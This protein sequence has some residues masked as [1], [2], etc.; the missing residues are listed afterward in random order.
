MKCKPKQR[1]TK[2][3]KS[4]CVLLDD[5]VLLRGPAAIELAEMCSALTGF[6]KEQR[7]KRN[8]LQPK[9]V[10]FRRIGQKIYFDI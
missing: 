6:S 4:C 9:S 5:W 8:K 7:K 10:C 3:H 1:L 2:G